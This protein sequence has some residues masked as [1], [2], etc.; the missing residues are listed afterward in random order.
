[1]STSAYAHVT[2]SD[3]GISSSGGGGLSSTP[4]WAA[5]GSAAQEHQLNE[6]DAGQQSTR[7]QQ[8]VER[9]ICV[10]FVSLHACCPYLSS[11]L[12]LQNWDWV[13]P[14]LPGLCRPPQPRPNTSQ[15]HSTQQ[16]ARTIG[17]AQHTHMCALTSISD[18]EC[19]LREALDRCDSASESP[20]SG[21][22][23]TRSPSAATHTRSLHF[24]RPNAH[25]ILPVLCVFVLLSARPGW[26]PC[27]T[28][29]SKC[30]PC[31]FT[32]SLHSS[33]IISSSVRQQ[34]ERTTQKLADIALRAR[35]YA[36][37]GAHRLHLFVSVLVLML[38]CSIRHLRAVARLRLLDG[39]QTE[40][41]NSMHFSPHHMRCLLM[42]VIARCFS[43][44]ASR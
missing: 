22:T 37:L 10:S 8:S 7:Q 18:E 40:R 39:Q 33:L 36:L 15:K 28:F 11:R 26:H 12:L 5:V 19:M 20:K 6:P 29:C 34:H 2:S 43:C 27:F 25:V 38:S 42:T 1:M 24:R 44:G 14:P 21:A 23:A 13:R 4:D 17:Q 41:M 3:G 30:P 32:S 35:A 9:C 16:R 31:W